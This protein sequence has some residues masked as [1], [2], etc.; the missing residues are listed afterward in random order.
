MNAKL[1]LTALAT[2]TVFAGQAVAQGSPP[3]AGGSTPSRVGAVKTIEG[4]LASVIVVRG[5]QTYALLD[6]DALFEGDRIITRSN[7]RVNIAVYNCEKALEPTAS[8]VLDDE[9]CAVAPVT[10]ASNDPAPGLASPPSV[11]TT[12]VGATPAMVM[13]L[14]GGGGAASALSSSN[15]STSSTD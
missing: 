12:L 7:G 8:I 13:L 1:V 4:P 14:A 10:V 11:S 2:I 3:P 15:S 5:A 9:V 6:G